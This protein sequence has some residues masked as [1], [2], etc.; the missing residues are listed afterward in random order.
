MVK[1]FRM[2]LL[3][4]CSLPAMAQGNSIEVSVKRVNTGDHHVF[5]VSGGAG[6]HPPPA[7]LL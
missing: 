6:G 1:R 3:L 4:F 2:Y 7:L 5:D